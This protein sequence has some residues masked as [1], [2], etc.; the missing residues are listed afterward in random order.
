[1]QKQTV[2]R[3]SSAQCSSDRPMSIGLMMPMAE[4]SAFGG[5]PRF[6]DIREMAEMAEDIGLD[7]ISFADHFVSRP[8]DPVGVRGF[9]EAG[10]IVAAIA[11]CTRRVSL[12]VLVACA[13]YRNPFVTAKIAETLDEISNGRFILGMGAGWSKPDFDMAGLAFDY[14][15][16]RFEE[17]LAIIYPLLKQGHVDFQGGYYTAND[18]LNT[19]RG[20][21]KDVGG[22]PIMLG[23]KGPRMMDLTA[24]F[25]DAWNAV[26]FSD[27]NH[28]S[29]LLKALD[30]ACVAAGRAPETLTKTTGGHIAM[31]GYLGFRP[32]PIRG[33]PAEIAKR[34]AEF[35]SLGIH[36]FVAS[37]DPCTP[38]TIEE[39]GRVLEIFDQHNGV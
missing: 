19:P 13:L 35:R 1:M 37:L 2:S 21:R 39:F 16:S 14:R 31:T 22:V 6:Q 33:D 12:S 4:Q 11:A 29:P 38:K 15:V 32:D 18:A 8:D 26:Y 7:G 5:S 24:R 9:W 10:S 36:H 27:P 30:D 34:L 25:A 23:T 28:L 20:P 3:R 17:A